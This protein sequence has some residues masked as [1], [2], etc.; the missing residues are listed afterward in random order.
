MAHGVKNF[1]VFM[2]M[3]W[4]KLQSPQDSGPLS[5]TG[6]S[7][8]TPYIFD[9]VKALNVMLHICAGAQRLGFG[10]NFPLF[11]F[12]NRK[13][14]TYRG[15]HSQIFTNL[16]ST[17]Q[18][19]LTDHW[20]SYVAILFLVHNMLQLQTWHNKML[21]KPILLEYGSSVWDPHTQNLIKQVEAVQNRAARFVS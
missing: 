1:V 5:L 7:I 21:V 11:Y 8:K 20:A 3:L 19:K 15:S 6:M 14:K 17:S 16:P 10:T 12:K 4:L 9:M 2:L 18:Q 13:I